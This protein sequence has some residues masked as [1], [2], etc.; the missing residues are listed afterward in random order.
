MRSW[1][2]KTNAAAAL[3]AAPHLTLLHQDDF[4]LPGRAAALRRWLTTWPDAAL[5]VHST[6]I[7]DRH[8]RA[9]GQWRSP[10]PAERSLGCADVIEPLLVQNFIA[11]PSTVFS[12]AAYR[13]VGGM[14]PEL[15]YTADWDLW[16]KLAS[17]GSVVYHP[18]SFACFRIHG[19][20]L[21]VVGASEKEGL[22]GQLDTVLNKHLDRLGNSVTPQT[23]ARAR[24]SV[25]INAGLAAAFG[26]KTSAMLSAMWALLRLG[27]M[28]ASRYLTDSR[29]LERVVP[30]LKARFTRDL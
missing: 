15:W 26:G 16:L 19:R 20:S 30:R 11:I 24:A 25:D 17:R 7:V 21:T 2:D 5:Q 1:V 29:L 4:W 28:Q 12:S 9:L 22:R 27:P 14:D 18:D 3:A 6:T 10:L 23:V 8:G 13:S